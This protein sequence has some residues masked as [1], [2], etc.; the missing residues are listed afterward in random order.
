MV[1]DIKSISH[2]IE[3]AQEL[4]KRVKQEVNKI[5]IGQ[6]TLI[7]YLLIGM[8]SNG[9]LIIEGVP[10]IAKTLAANTLARTL[11]CDFKRI[12]F[13]P[14]LLPAD[15]TGTP[16]YRAKE[17][18]F[19]VKK[20]PIFTHILLADEIN[21]APSKV[22]SALLEVMQERQVTIGG[23]TF[24]AP[25]PF[26]VLATQNPIEQEGTYPLAEA[27]TDRFMMKIKIS[28]PS[29]EEE[30]LILHRISNALPL[31]PIHPVLEIETLLNL[32]QLV[33]AIYLD[34]KVVE[35]L[36]DIVQAT[37][38]PDLFKAPVKGLL[39]YGASPR[40]TLALKQGAKARALLSGRYFVTPQDIKDMALPILRHRLRLS[41]EAEAENL[42]TDDII[43]QILDALPVP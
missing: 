31:P 29:R 35:Y 21:R 20:G 36:L 7:D 18:V 37:R 19:E 38:N 15:L 26:L 41:Y 3:N 24:P 8:L 11:H 25:D 28:Y 10:G 17:G 33:E 6:E 5:I 12:Q 14:D 1:L 34:E 22:Q 40:A 43:H 27:Q 4:L 2:Q 9:H 13:T 16:I 32:R 39:E 23:E 30:K 42:T